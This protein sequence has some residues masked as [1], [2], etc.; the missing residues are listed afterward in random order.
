M[1]DWMIDYYLWIKAMHVIS[2]IAW[3]AALLYLPRLF[4]YHVN[5]EKGS[6]QSE[7]FKT[8]ERRLLFFI[9]KPAM[10]ATFLFGA[11]LL[12]ANPA[13]FA[14]GWMHIKLTA[15]IILSIIQILFIR[16]YKAFSRDENVKSQRFFRILNE[17]PTLLMVIIVI[18]VIVQ[19]FAK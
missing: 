11:L 8:M 14:A 9:S 4:V 19:P 13:L 16:Y 2:I 3:M 18:M 15:V 12:W 5:A 1:Q 6:V 10:I 7:T 17:I